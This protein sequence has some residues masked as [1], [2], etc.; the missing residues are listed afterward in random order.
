THDSAAPTPGARAAGP[1]KI[2]VAA[3]VRHRQARHS[4]AQKV[5]PE[6]GL[7]PG[8]FRC[9]ILIAVASTPSSWTRSKDRPLLMAR[10]MNG[11]FE[12]RRDIRLQRDAV[13]FNGRDLV[14]AWRTRNTCTVRRW[15][16]L[17]PLADRD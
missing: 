12:C 16:L 10:P 5:L 14:C 4:A 8:L 9:A 3:Y 17:V 13:G 11:Q 2:E 6:V 7:D 1:R 15:E